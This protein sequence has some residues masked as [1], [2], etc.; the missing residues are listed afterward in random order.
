LKAGLR[1]VNASEVEVLHL[2]VRRY[3]PEFRALSRRYMAG[4][5]AALC[6]NARL[7]GGGTRGLYFRWLGDLLAWNV[8]SA[9]TLS[10]PT[11]IRYTIA[12]VE[13]SLRSLSYR[14]DRASGLF[15]ER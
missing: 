12:Y 9:V 14:L 2:G 3:G 15:V 7:G 10:R 4:T 8:R 1:I 13:G 5:G 11:G 6:K